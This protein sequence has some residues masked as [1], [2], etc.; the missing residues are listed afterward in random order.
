MYPISVKHTELSIEYLLY[1]MLSPTFTKHVVDCSMRVAMP[2]VNREALGNSWLWY[3]DLGEQKRTVEYI[4]KSTSSI[5][6][7]IDFM[8]RDIN[9]LREYRT[10]LVADVVT[11]KV[12]VRDIAARLPDVNESDIL[13]EAVLDDE[14]VITDEA[15]LSGEDSNAEC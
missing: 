10:R 6:S 3:P 13:E 1:L 5:K 8:K 14:L 9:L 2:K 7:N 11:G 15:K 4:Q 12:D